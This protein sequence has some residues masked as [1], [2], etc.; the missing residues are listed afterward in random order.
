MVGTMDEPI[1]ATPMQAPGR[2]VEPSPDPGDV[3]EIDHYEL[4]GIPLYHIP[5]PGATI[6]TL[7]FGVGR[8]D[9]PVVRGGMTHLAEHLILTSIDDALDHS[10]GTTEAFR[11]TFVTRGSPSHVS[12]FLR[13]VCAAIEAPRLSRIHQEAKVLR[14]EAAGRGG[15]GMSL[16]LAWMR[17]G[18]QGIGTVGMPEFF[19]DAPDEEVLRA[20]IAKTFVTGNAAIWIAG[21]LPDDLTV[22]LL[23]GPRLDRPAPRWIDGF[24][25]PTMVVDDAAAVGASFLVER[26]AAMGAAFHAL[27]R[28]LTRRI[29]VDRG[30]GYEV[31]NEWLALDRDQALATVWVTCLPEATRDVQQIVLETV[32]DVA[33]RGPTDDE[34]SRDY[35]TFP[36]DLGDP[37]GF[38]SRLDAH[39]RDMLLG[40]DPVPR[41]VASLLEERWRL[42]SAHVAAAFKHARDS[43]LFVLPRSG[44]DPQRPFKRYPG[45]PTDAM[46]GDRTF[47]LVTKGRGPFH[48][49][50]AARL[51][52][53]RGGLAVDVKAR[54]LMAVR[55]PDCVAIIRER[56]TRRV[57]GRDGSVVHVHRSDWRDGGAALSLVDKLGPKD[58]VVRADH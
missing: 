16:R 53:G 44:I 1:D 52:I 9:E 2:S 8:A 36:Q 13:D 56:D 42:E 11:V 14:T 23:Q 26:S 51:S 20:W 22:A 41:T 5:T 40:D 49:A 15:M 4:D 55:W 19:L 50:P 37:R 6:L 25:T 48:K 39:V 47:E 10:N 24:E 29:R 45:P 32:D 31:G 43:M 21:E 57:L 34:L 54:R 46:G 38:P 18:Y 27:N 7:A 58:L 35:Q 17:A 33:S 12:R 30:L 3:P 28:Q